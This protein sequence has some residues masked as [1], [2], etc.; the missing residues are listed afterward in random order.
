MELTQETLDRWLELM[1]PHPTLL[2]ELE[3]I[4]LALGELDSTMMAIV[5][6]ISQH[7]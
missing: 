6:A 3:R 2:R 5:E 1:L 7:P 4:A